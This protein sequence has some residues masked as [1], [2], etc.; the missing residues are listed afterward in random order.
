VG[1]KVPDDGRE[2]ELVTRASEASQ[3]HSFEAVVG[4]QM[5]EGRGISRIPPLFH[6]ST[7]YIAG[8]FVNISRY[9]APRDVRTTP[10]LQRARSALKDQRVA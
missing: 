7:R 6:E 5:R 8:L 9:F 4:L 2:V 1:L 10:R 3:A